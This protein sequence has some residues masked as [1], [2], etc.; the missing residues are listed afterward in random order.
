MNKHSYKLVLS[1]HSPTIPH[2]QIVVF[3]QDCLGIS[4][5]MYLAYK[6]L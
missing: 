1:Q 6:Y 5:G 4:L 3:S 2:P